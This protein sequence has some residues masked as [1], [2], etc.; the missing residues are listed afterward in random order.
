MYGYIPLIIERFCVMTILRKMCFFMLLLTGLF[1]LQAC[2][3][4]DGPLE[5][6][7]EAIDEAGEEIADEIDDAT[8]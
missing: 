7:G 6:A 1:G 4:N 2:D 5:E 3:T 8:D